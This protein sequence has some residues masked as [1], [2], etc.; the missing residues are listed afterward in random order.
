VVVQ[1][2]GGYN[3]TTNGLS[4]FTN[5]LGDGA[6]G[7]SALTAGRWY[8][9][10]ASHFGTGA[11]GNS[12]WIWSREG[13][14]DSGSAGAVNPS[15]TQ[16]DADAGT[17]PVFISRHNTALPRELGGLISDLMFFNTAKHNISYA[18]ALQNATSQQ[19]DPTLNWYRT[20]NVKAAAAVATSYLPLDLAHQPQHQAIMAM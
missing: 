5:T 18:Y 15:L 13:G 19:Y 3:G 11:G 1:I 6:W 8:F 16:I 14:W 20:P 7:S 17:N 2:N 10:L 9:F 12:L 4:L